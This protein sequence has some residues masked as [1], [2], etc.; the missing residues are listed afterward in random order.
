VLELGELETVLTSA[1]IGNVGQ[2]R[3]GGALVYD[4]CS[5]VEKTYICIRDSTML[6]SL[7][8]SIGI[9]CVFITDACESFCLQV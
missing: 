9:L 3:G 4:L 2:K 8:F 1:C 7:V 5:D 6:F